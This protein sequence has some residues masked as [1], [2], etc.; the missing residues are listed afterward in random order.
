MTIYK[1]YDQKELDAQYNNRAA[2]PDF[3]RI[4]DG[5]RAMSAASRARLSHVLDLPYW[6]NARE[7]LDV[8]PAG[9]G[10]PVHVFFHGGYWV[11]MDKTVFHFI[12]D[13]F[14]S[15]GIT[16]VFANYPLAPKA[17]MDQIVRSC[18]RA[19]LWVWERIAFYGGDPERIFVSGHSAGGHLTAMLMATGWSALHPAAPQ[20]LVKGGLSLSGLF[21]LEPI[22]LSYLNK[23]IGLDEDTARRNSPI[24]HLPAGAAPLLLAVGEHESEEYHAQSDA[25]QRA[26]LPYGLTVERVTTDADDHF[27]ILS[28]LSDPA[29]TLFKAYQFLIEETG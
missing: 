14:V 10:A 11:A 15:N 23:R 24:Y 27:S 6:S 2:V 4:V 18:R 21:D 5:W 8:F 29:G 19:L 25:L 22:R 16:T 28:R 9:P 20:S 17:H 13:H 26:W 1:S 12:A 3:E 7:R